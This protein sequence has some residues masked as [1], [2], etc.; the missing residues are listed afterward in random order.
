MN[1]PELGNAMNAKRPGTSIGQLLNQIPKNED[2]V[3][4]L[5]LRCL[6]RERVPVLA[7]GIGARWLRRPPEWRGI[8]NFPSRR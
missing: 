4:E 7:P 5:Y 1:A 2:L 8:Q 3:A 6:A